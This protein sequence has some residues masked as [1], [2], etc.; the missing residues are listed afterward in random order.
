MNNKTDESVVLLK[1]IDYMNTLIL[2]VHSHC[3][4]KDS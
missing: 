2:S 4:P 3:R 1:L